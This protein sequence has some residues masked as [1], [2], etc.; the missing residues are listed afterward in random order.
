MPRPPTPGFAHGAVDD[1]A[2]GLW[3][4]GRSLPRPTRH[5]AVGTVVQP[6]RWIPPG[7]RGLVQTAVKRR[8][9]SNRRVLLGVCF[10]TD[11]VGRSLSAHSKAFDA[12]TVPSKS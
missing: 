11:V 9:R 10:A 2:L 7:R 1:G 8:G 6:L 3:H 12:R 5:G 4:G